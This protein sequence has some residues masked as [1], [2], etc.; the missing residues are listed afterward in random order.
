MKITKLS[1]IAALAISAAFAGG[2]IEKPEVIIVP[3]PEVATT[4]DGLAKLYFMSV[5]PETGTATSGSAG[6]VTL[7][8]S[9]KLFDGV[10]ANFSAVGTMN[11]APTTTADNITLE[12]TTATLLKNTDGATAGAFFNVANLTM[13]YGGTTVI[14]G[15]QLINSPMV[16]GY[17]WIMAPGAFEAYTVVNSSIS[18]LT[19]VGTYLTKWRPNRKGDMWIDLTSDQLQST[20]GNS[21]NWA[22]GA[23]Y[24]AGDYGMLSAW[25]YNVDAHDYTQIYVDYGVKAYGMGVKAQYIATTYGTGATRD[26]ANT[27]ASSSYG[28][29]VSAEVAGW[30]LA[31]AY[32]ALTDGN[33]E[34]IGRDGLYTTSWNTQAGYQSNGAADT[35]TTYKVTASGDLFGLNTSVSYGGYGD[36]NEIDAILNYSYNKSVGAMLVYTNVTPNAIGDGNSGT[37]YSTLE[38]AVNYKF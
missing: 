38:I 19:L 14:A 18:N 35:T 3:T 21:A 1:L 20:D 4:V 27:D 26:I 36:G 13:T 25:Y 33:T 34:Y 9:H 17:D 15:R 28:V 24:N 30:T 37:Q 16:G 8:V 31:A 6:G 10:T 32:N 2:D 22:G 12:D 7:N 23:I 11:F 29:E 5:T